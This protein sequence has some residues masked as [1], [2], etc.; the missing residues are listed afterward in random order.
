V[1]YYHIDRIRTL[2]PPREATAVKCVSLADDVFVDHFPGHPIL[3]GAIL[4]EGLAQLAG[5][6]LE[7]TLR[8]RGRENLHALLV[9]VERARFRRRV[10]PGDRVDMRAEV[11]TAQ[12]DGGQARVTAFVD[13]ERAAEAELGFAF[14]VVNSPKIL[15]ARREALNIWLTGSAEEL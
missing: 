5:V 12:E 10:V 6:L 15:A 4:I 9:T 1:R 11:L 3:P 13:G 8:Q 2:E 7:A 14:T